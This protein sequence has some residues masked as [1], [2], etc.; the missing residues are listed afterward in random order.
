VKIGALDIG[1]GHPCAIVAEIGNAHGGSLGR[2]IHLLDAAKACGASAAK[3]QSYTPDEL[4]ALRG[5][6]PAPSQWGEQGWSMRDLYTKA[7]T[8]LAWLPT[9]YAHAESIGLPLFSSVFGPESLA[10]LEA[11]GNPVYKLARIDNGHAWLL[12]AAEATGKPCLVSIGPDDLTAENSL[13]DRENVWAL[14][15]TPDY[16]T[17]PENVLLPD[18]SEAYAV[19][20]NEGGYLGLSSHCLDPRLPIAAVARGASLLEYHFMLDSEPSELESSVSLGEAAFRRMVDDV[21]ATEVLLD[22]Y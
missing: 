14:W 3:L 7:Q 10:A 2:A 11:V 9:L 13:Y 19:N 20:Q 4:V 5:D 1:P 15:C 21:R 8:P 12:D 6:G 16:P 18:F 22:A 17:T